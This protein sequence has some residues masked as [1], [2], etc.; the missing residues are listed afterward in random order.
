MYQQSVD[1]SHGSSKSDLLLFIVLIAAFF[2][3]GAVVLFL[4]NKFA[5][6]IPRYVFIGLVLTALYLV[7][8]LRLIGYRYTVFYE[9]PKPV[10]DERFGEMML[11]E[12]YPYPV[13]TI[14]FERIVRAKGTVMYTVGA[15]DVKALL[16][17]GEEP[18]GFG[19]EA[20]TVNVSCRKAAD[21]YSVLFDNGGKPI[22]LYFDPDA[23]F[24]SHLS[25]IMNDRTD[26]ENAIEENGE[27]DG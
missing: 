8:R 7:Y 10:Y 20:R 24:L 6:R 16:K 25:A 5:S 1:R 4:E 9:E 23:E 26:T 15:K 2:A 22:R 17:P 13:G 12:D 14:V 11:H 27:A 18:V 19:D 3:V 21:A